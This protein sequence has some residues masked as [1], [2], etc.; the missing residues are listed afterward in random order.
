VSRG[1]LLEYWVSVAFVKSY[2]ETAR[3]ASFFA[4]DAR[5]DSDSAGLCLLGRGIYEL[6]YHL[7]HHPQRIHIPLK[8]I[9][10]LLQERD[11]REPVHTPRPPA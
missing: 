2:L 10:H 7:L 11:R 5:R 4:A 6:H 8:A 3:S 1:T 9:L